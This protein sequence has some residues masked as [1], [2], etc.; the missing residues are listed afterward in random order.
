MSEYTIVIESAG[1]G[2]RFVGKD[3]SKTRQDYTTNAARA[4]RLKEF[5]FAKNF[6]DT[7]TERTGNR[8]YVLEGGGVAYIGR[9][10]KRRGDNNG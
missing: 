5:D 2:R 7:W 9:A 6:A 8:F 3:H 1:L 10:N 4:L